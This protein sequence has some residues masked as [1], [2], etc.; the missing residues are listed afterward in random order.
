MGATQILLP[1]TLEQS[2]LQGSEVTRS[3][4]G[5]SDEELR[6]LLAQARALGL[7]VAMMPVLE[8]CG[9]PSDASAW[10]GRVAPRDEDAWWRSYERELLALARLAS[11]G[12]AEV[13]VIGSEMSSLSSEAHEA[14]WS[15]LAAS[16]RAAFAGQLAYVANFDALDARAPLGAVDIAGVSAYFPIASHEEASQEEMQQAWYRAADR[17][18]Q[19]AREVELPVM[20]FEFG[21]PSRDGGAMRP[22]DY[23]RGTPVDLEEQRRAYAAASDVLL[24]RPLIRGAYAWVYFG[25][26]G[27]HDRWY[28]WRGK[29]AEVELRRLLAGRR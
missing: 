14:R 5:A 12:S 2:G 3:P 27:A 16:A 8:I 13:L 18:D 28:T 20:L 26:G 4:D 19:F 1:V 17:I 9:A 21:Y 23:A 22:W 7:G 24:D 29:P 15:G 25:Q 11:E 6:A 10:R